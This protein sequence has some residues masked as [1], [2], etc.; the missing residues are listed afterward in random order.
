MC[1][2]KHWSNRD[3]DLVLSIEDLAKQL[4]GSTWIKSGMIRIYLNGHGK[5]IK[6][7]F[8]FDDMTDPQK[9][10]IYKGEGII[11]GSQLK[12]FSNADQ[13][14][15]WKINRAKQVKYTIMKQVQTLYGGEIPDSWEN[16]I[17]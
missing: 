4:K 14:R 11:L 5:D 15:L 7:F 17:L 13:S 2:N 3:P 9:I 8:D 16:V 1:D 10:E 12:V 6:A